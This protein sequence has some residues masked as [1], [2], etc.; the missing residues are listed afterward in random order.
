MLV[1]KKNV[2]HNQKKNIYI[3]IV[4]NEVNVMDFEFRGNVNFS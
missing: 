2:E 1:K 3:Y 4:I